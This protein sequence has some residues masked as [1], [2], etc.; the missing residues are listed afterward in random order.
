MC[1]YGRRSYCRT[2]S[3]LP[4]AAIYAASGMWFDQ[5]CTQPC[6][7]PKKTVPVL[8]F[9]L[10]WNSGSKNHCE[11]MELLK[12][13]YFFNITN[14][15]FKIDC[16]ALPVAFSAVLY[17]SS[18]ERKYSGHLHI[19]FFCGNSLR[20]L[21]ELLPFSCLKLLV[22]CLSSAVNTILKQ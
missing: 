11:T 10:L 14:I 5:I 21:H 4:T 2:I 20:N 13:C 7:P 18:F 22:N 6:P 12:I 16:I 3:S 1:I 19:Q 15:H 9:E 8:F 17:L